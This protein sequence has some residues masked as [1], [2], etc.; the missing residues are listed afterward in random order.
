M[1]L[2]CT[3][4]PVLCF[5]NGVTAFE[6]PLGHSSIILMNSTWL[7]SVH[8]NHLITSSSCCCLD[9]LTHPDLPTLH[10]LQCDQAETF[11]IC[12]FDFH[13]VLYSILFLFLFLIA[14]NKKSGEVISSSYSVFRDLFCHMSCFTAITSD[15]H[16]T[17]G[18]EHTS[19][20]SCNT[21]Y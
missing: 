18:H 15:I 6:K 1:M 2:S 9:N 10:S 16:G 19:A 11:Q 8:T 14:F 17:G 20:M 5:C 7:H 12:K 21:L 4:N 13:L 3:C